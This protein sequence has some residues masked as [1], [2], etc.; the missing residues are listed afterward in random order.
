[1]LLWLFDRL[2]TVMFI[3]FYQ[4][5]VISL[6]MLFKV[7]SILVDYSILFFN[8][9]LITLLRQMDINLFSLVWKIKYI[10]DL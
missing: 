2:D 10:K 3:N 9:M 8:K 6:R 7:N 1:M 4:L 5:N